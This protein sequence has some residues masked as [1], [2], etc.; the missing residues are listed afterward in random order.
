LLDVIMPDLD[1][2][3]VCRRLK[4]GDATR[5]IPVI[6][7]TAKT[8]VDDMVRG[9][10]AGG[11]D[12]VVKPFAP[13]ELM[14]RVR[15]HLD[16]KAARDLVLAQTRKIARQHG[17]LQALSE[18][19]TQ[20]YRFLVEDVTD[21]LGILQDDRVVFVNQALAALL[22]YAADDLIGTAAFSPGAEDQQAD[23]QR[24][25]ALLFDRDPG[26]QWQVLQCLMCA[27]GRE[28]WLEGRQSAIIW[29]GRPAALVSLRDISQHKRGNWR[30]E[31]VITGESGT[32]KELAARAIH[33]ASPRRNRPFVAINC[34]AIPEGLKTWNARSKTAC[35]AK[36][37]SIAWR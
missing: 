5:D 1:G 16:L 36:T 14:A 29:E 4:A 37:C 35:C 13:A 11:V 10:Q 31:A 8:Q 15:T 18:R 19:V 30:F 33:A 27:D 25:R 2:F 26:E 28:L 32:G 22:G 20:Q 23:I 6:F 9:F 12:Y 3:E 7:L 24:V 17:E 34:A 21:G